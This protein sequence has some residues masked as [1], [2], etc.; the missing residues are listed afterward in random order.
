M[1]LGRFT[2]LE[3]QNEA[4]KRKTSVM[5]RLGSEEKLCLR[6]EESK[7]NVLYNLVLPRGKLERNSAGSANSGRKLK[8]YNSKGNYN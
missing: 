1:I 8:E 7:E 5:K 4:V 2:C 6:V 3:E